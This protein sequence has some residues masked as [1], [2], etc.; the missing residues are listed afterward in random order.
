MAWSERRCDHLLGDSAP[1]YL[2]IGSSCAELIGT[3]DRALPSDYAG[4]LQDCAVIRAHV[5]GHPV[6]EIDV[7]AH[8]MSWHDFKDSGVR[9]A[10]YQLTDPS[11]CALGPRYPWRPE[12]ASAQP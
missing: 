10:I 9:L 11:I 6:E 12:P 7:P 3:P 4:W 5:A 1:T 2:Y 8:K